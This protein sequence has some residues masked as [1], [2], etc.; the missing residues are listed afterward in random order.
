M[1]IKQ[2]PGVCPLD[3]RR[4][5]SLRFYVDFYEDSA[6]AVP[7]DISGFSYRAQIR[8]RAN[9]TEPLAV[10]NVSHDYSSVH[11]L[12]VELPA[13]VSE[14]LAPTRPGGGYQWDLEQTDEAG[15]V[16]TVLAGTVFVTADVTREI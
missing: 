9:D 2:S 3:F 15:Y 11:R 10:M 6:Q 4:G 16:V 8:A 1:A 13:A 12:W 7:I 14:S 5:D